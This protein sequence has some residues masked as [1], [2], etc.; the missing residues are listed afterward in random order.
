MVSVGIVTGPKIHVIFHG[1]WKGDDGPVNNS[2]LDISQPTKFT[3]CSNDA[4]FT[5]CNVTIGID[6]HWQRQENQTFKGILTVI[7][8]GDLL[9]AVNIIS[10][11]DYLVSVISSEMNPNANIEFLKAAAVISRSWVRRQQINRIANHQSPT[12]QAGQKHTHSTIVEWHDHQDHTLF[13]VCADDHCQR[14]QGLTRIINPNALLAVK[15]T[16]GQ[17][18]TYG[19]EICDCRFSKCCGGTTEQYNTCWEDKSVPYLQ[20]VRDADPKDGHIFC[21]TTDKS[22]LSQVLNSYDQET[23]HFYRWTVNYTQQELRQLLF[24]KLNR[25]F[26]QIKALTPIHRGPSGR[27]SLL[28]I[29]GTTDQLS[30]GKELAIR[31]ALSESHLYSS[32]FTVEPT[33]I[34]NEGVPQRFVIQGK[35]WGHGVGLCQIGAAVMASE[36]YDYQQILQHYYPHTKLTTANVNDKI[37]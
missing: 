1:C 26:G 34:N 32:A 33:D 20:S 36:G 14:Y 16:S 6:Y 31:S 27:I 37:K 18:L 21:N 7:R 13:D 30:I 22:V 11:E 4:T 9:T 15:E 29:E 25:D 24:K 10:I 35:G 17:V 2:E 5:L 8:D 23:T 3:P 19:E 28:K 12:Y